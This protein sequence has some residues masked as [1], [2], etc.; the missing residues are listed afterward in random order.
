MHIFLSIDIFYSKRTSEG[1]GS[2]NDLFSSIS[3]RLNQNKYVE[4]HFVFQLF[5]DDLPTTKPP[6]LKSKRQRMLLS[7]FFLLFVLGLHL[8]M[9]F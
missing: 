6:N 1:P 5:Y 4:M 8:Q 7:E 2:R 3:P 9:S